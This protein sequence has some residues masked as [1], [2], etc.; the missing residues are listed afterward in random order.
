M[1]KLLNVEQIAEI[2][3]VKKSTI[4]EWTH[5]KFIPFVKFGKLVRFRESDILNW[6]QERSRKTSEKN[7]GEIIE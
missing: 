7:T 6:L 3:Q 4:R 2:L 5:K 1:E